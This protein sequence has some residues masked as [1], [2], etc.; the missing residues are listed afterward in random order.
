MDIVFK[1]SKLE[2]NC[3]NYQAAVRAWGEP[4]ARKLVQRL[5][6]FRA[7]DTLSVISHLPPPRLHKLD[8][9]R[10]DEYAVDLVHPARLIFRIHQ[11]PIP[12]CLDGGVDRS[13]VTSI[14]IVEVED[15]HGKQKR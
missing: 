14:M 6:E 15:Y 2:K 7:A 1:T 12:L 13:K 4:M 9:R 3:N 11:E 5:N 10:G 8:G